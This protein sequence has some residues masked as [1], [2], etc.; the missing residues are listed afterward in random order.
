VTVTDEVEDTVPFL[1]LLPLCCGGCCPSP[2]SLKS[3]CSA[4][5][6]STGL[7]DAAAARCCCECARCPLPATAADETALRPSEEVRAGDLGG[8]E[9]ALPEREEDSAT[10]RR[11]GEDGV[12]LGTTT[13]DGGGGGRVGGLEEAD[14]CAVMEADAAGAGRGDV[15]W[16]SSREES[17]CCGGVVA[18][19]DG[20]SD[21]GTTAAAEREALFAAAARDC[22]NGEVRGDL[23]AELRGC[24]LTVK[25][26]EAAAR[27]R[28]LTMALK[29]R[30]SELKT[31]TSSPS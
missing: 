1:S 29:T 20:G 14:S 7:L 30:R 9:L 19:N 15:G 8:E 21:G 24:K 27:A 4:C 26:D 2:L 31:T 12:C 11:G 28:V 25:D 5:C 18:V 22:K 13:W 17:G 6:P 10:E 16:Y 23:M 3:F